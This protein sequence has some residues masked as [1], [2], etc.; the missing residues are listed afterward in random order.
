MDKETSQR[1]FMRTATLMELGEQLLR[2]FREGDK[3]F[4]TGGEEFMILLQKCDKRAGFNRG[5]ELS[6]YISTYPFKGREI[7][8]H[9]QI[10]ISLGVASYPEDGEDI[11]Q[12]I[13]K[14]DQ[15]CYIAKES[16]RNQVIL[17]K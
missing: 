7:Q 11:N 16:G 9:G 1:P 4:R 5:K 2:F 10:T 13:R 8:P 17:A 12:L 14:A 6:Q 3:V 15:A